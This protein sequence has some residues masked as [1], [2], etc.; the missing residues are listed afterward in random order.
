MIM[1]VYSWKQ[2]WNNFNSWDEG[3]FQDANR[4]RDDDKFK[5]RPWLQS[6]KWK[7]REVNKDIT[8]VASQLVAEWK[9]DN[10]SSAV[11]MPTDSTIS[12]LSESVKKWNPWC[13][14]NKD[15]N[16]EIVEDGT[17]IIQAFTQFRPSTTPSNSYQY[18]E[19][20]GLL[21]HKTWNY[22]WY[23][24]TLRALG[25]TRMCGSGD[26]VMAWWS[27]WFTKWA[28]LNVGA[29]HTYTSTMELKQRINIQR[30]A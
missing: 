23:G 12:K 30:L 22:T 6:D 4:P 26:E 1:K 28:V 18:V 27:W 3:L 8:T 7:Q 24:R 16:I 14:V 15:W 29:L 13:V 17:Y 25:Q 2:Y 10:V 9:T 21:V 20:V 19:E 5:I 11:N